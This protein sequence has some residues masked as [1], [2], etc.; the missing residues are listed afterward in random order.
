MINDKVS[1]IVPVYNAEKYLG[2]TITSILK[3]TYQNIEI[4]LVNDGS[5]DDSLIICQNYAAIDDRIKVLDIPN[6]GVSNARNCGIESSTGKYI[7]FVDSDDVIAENMTERLVETMYVYEAD[8]VICGMRYM[9]LEGNRPVSS[10]DWLPQYLGKECVLSREKFVGDFSRILLYTVLLEGPCN[11]LYKREY[12][13]NYGFRFPLDKELGEDFLL[14]LQYFGKLERIVFISDVL[15]YYLQW[16]KN[17]LTTCYRSDMFDNQTLLLQEYEKFLRAQCVWK[18]ENITYFY[19][20]AVGHVI[21]CISMVFDSRNDSEDTGVKAELFRIL[22]ND[23]VIT[24]IQ[25]VAW[26]PEDY[27][28]LKQCV[29][30]TDIGLAY[31]KLVNISRQKN[32]LNNEIEAGQ[33]V[34]N[35]GKVNQKLDQILRRINSILNSQKVAKVIGSLEDDGIKIT[36]SKVRKSCRYRGWKTI[37]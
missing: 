26:I 24:W 21:R 17:S 16:G 19:Q 2:Y 35:P 3:Q 9:V 20:Y 37:K 31:D 5:K 4:I 7:Q 18:D 8:M 11:K 12:F 34:H 28:W 32:M 29:K 27:E 6:G 36:I 15:Y 22:N 25:N 1:I 13:E 14:N 30:N 23:S 10:N 33:E